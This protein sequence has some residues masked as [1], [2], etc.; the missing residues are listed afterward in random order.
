M[1]W[2]SLS[3]PLQW[4]GTTLQVTI[5]RD[6]LRVAAHAGEPVSFTVRGVEYTV[7]EESDVI[8]PLADQG[9]VLEGRPTL[10]QFED[11]RRDDG[12]LISASVPVVTT[13]IPIIGAFED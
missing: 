7:S 6:Q 8:A 3:Y 1:D 2:P 11:A 10:G 12:T 4:Q 13:A 5:T 9:P